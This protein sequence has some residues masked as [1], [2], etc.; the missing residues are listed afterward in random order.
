MFF[1]LFPGYTLTFEFLCVNVQGS[2]NG[3]S[4]TMGLLI[5][6]YDSCCRPKIANGESINPYASVNLVQQSYILPVSTHNH[7]LLLSF[8]GFQKTVRTGCIEGEADAR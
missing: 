1:E 2:S 8:A 5:S 7:I 4:V 6:C 3:T